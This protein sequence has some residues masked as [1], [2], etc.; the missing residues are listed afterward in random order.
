VRR[1][2]FLG[3][4]GSIKR[5][6]PKPH[7]EA[8]WLGLALLTATLVT[9]QSVA[10]PSV[11]QAQTSTPTVNWSQVT[12]PGAVA[13]VGVGPAGEVWIATTDQKLYQ[14]HGNSFSVVA[15][16]TASP[17]ASGPADAGAV[18]RVAVGQ[19]GVPWI[20]NKVGDG[21]GYLDNAWV[22]MPNESMLHVAVDVGAGANGV[23]WYAHVGAAFDVSL[24]DALEFV[25]PYDG[26]DNKLATLNA[27]KI[28][29]D[30]NGVAW[31][32]ALGDLP[33]LGGGQSGSAPATAVALGAGS[34]FRQTGSAFAKIPGQAQDI[35]VGANGAVWIVSRDTSVSLFNGSGWTRMSGPS[36]TSGDASGSAISVGPDGSPWVVNAQGQLWKG[37]LQDSTPA[38]SQ[39]NGTPT[40]A[41]VVSAATST[42]PP[43]PVATA[44]A[45]PT[46]TATDQTVQDEQ[47][48]P[49][50]SGD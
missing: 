5:G 25:P 47:M 45:A 30:P 41:N 35:G 46:V 1:L 3:L 8:G 38:A 22:S 14:M 16:P 44:L 6:K 39:S 43:V 31:A 26:W 9:W 7:K 37:T 12:T 33:A 15:G 28:A 2:R 36:G 13:D 11:A 32:V 42:P 4:A 23:V 48:P 27:V 40:P 29:V 17:H 50:D 34:I 20:I 19:N 10:P 18:V 49:D 24:S 21:F